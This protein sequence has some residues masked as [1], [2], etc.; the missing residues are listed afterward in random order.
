MRRC[1]LVSEDSTFFFHRGIELEE[2]RSAIQSAIETGEKAR[3][4]STLTQQLVKNLFLSRDRTA[5][6]KLQELLLTFYLESTTKKEYLFELYVNLIEWGPDIYGVHDAAM[7]YFGRPPKKLTPKE[8]AYL[9]TIIPGPLL[10]H[11]HYER[12]RVSTKTNARV[13][14]LLERLNRLG[15][16]SDDELAA[17]KLEKIKF[18]KPKNG[19]KGG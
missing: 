7:H 8:M 4:G 1:I 14:N 10:Y 5:L 16:L 11:R 9:A 19:R 13:Q 3:G 15:Q 17:A 2:M 12:G 6:R 18:F